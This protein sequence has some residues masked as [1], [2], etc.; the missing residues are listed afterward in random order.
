MPFGDALLAAIPRWQDAEYI[1]FPYIPFRKRTLGRELK[2]NLHR[3]FRQ[4]AVTS[5]RSLAEINLDVN[6]MHPF[7]W[8]NSNGAKECF[9]GVGPP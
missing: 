7:G 5:K 1:T 9:Q 8:R 6:L 2:A 4:D 3:L